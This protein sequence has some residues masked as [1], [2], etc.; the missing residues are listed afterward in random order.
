MSDLQ[1]VAALET[2]ELVSTFVDRRMSLNEG[3]DN[4]ES[5]DDEE[6]L[7]TAR[8]LNDLVVYRAPLLRAEKGQHHVLRGRE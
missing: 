4:E 1:P 2:T 3:H 6:S 7:P 8:P 5:L